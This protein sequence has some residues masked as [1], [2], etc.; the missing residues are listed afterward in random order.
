MPITTANLLFRPRVPVF[1]AQVCVGGRRSEVGP[2]ATRPA[3]LDALDR[4]GITRA[5]VYHS[6]HS[7]RRAGWRCCFTPASSRTRCRAI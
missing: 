3:L 7:P 4:H 5:L 6:M 1:D 2:G